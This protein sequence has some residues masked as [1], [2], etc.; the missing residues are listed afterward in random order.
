MTYSWISPL[1]LK[2]YKTTLEEQDLAELNDSDYS[3]PLTDKLENQWNKV[4]YSFMSP[5]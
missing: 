5:T 3:I 4:K 2:G 1:V